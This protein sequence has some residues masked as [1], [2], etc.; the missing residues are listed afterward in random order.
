LVFGS[1]APKLS[2]EGPKGVKIVRRGAGQEH[3]KQLH[4]KNRFFI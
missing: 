4:D 3:L 2:D 1:E